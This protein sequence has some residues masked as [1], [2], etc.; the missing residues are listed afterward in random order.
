MDAPCHRLMNGRPVRCAHLISTLAG[1]W[2]RE[3]L[4]AFGAR[5][6]LRESW[7]QDRGTAWEHFDLLGKRIE[8]ARDA[9]AIKT[10]RAQFVGYL[11]RKR[12]LTGEVPSQRVRRIKAMLARRAGREYSQRKAA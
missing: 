5:I 10:D 8:A 4:L 3:E 6:G 9:G 1:R 12:E 7:L 2:G 11:R